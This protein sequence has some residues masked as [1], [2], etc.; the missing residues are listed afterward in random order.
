MSRKKKQFHK[1][2]TCGNCG[3][4]PVVGYLQAVKLVDVRTGVAVSTPFPYEDD[5]K[6]ICLSCLNVIKKFVVNRIAPSMW[7]DPVQVKFETTQ[8][9]G[10][11]YRE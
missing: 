7:K 9:P 1:Q 10:G 8:E 5:P 6:P 2:T 4:G 11:V 3:K